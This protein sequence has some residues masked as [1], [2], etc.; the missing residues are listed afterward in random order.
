VASTLIF[1]GRE[2]DGGEVPLTIVMDAYAHLVAFDKGR[3]GFAHLHPRAAKPG[4]TMVAAPDRNAPVLRFDL[5]IPRP[6][7][8]IIWA[9]VNLQN[10]E[11]FLP[12]SITVLP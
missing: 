4:D 10:H 7:A 11:H 3:S 12:F 9:Q 8:Y 5:T 2:Q 1:S 6:G